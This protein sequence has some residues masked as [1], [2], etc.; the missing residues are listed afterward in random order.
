MHSRSIHFSFRLRH[1]GRM[2]AMSFCNNTYCHLKGCN[3][4]CNFTDLTITEINFMLCRCSFMMRRLHFHSHIFQC[5]NHVTSRIFSKIQR[6][7][8]QV[9]RLLMCHSCRISI[10]I[11]M[12]Q[13]KLTF[14]IN[15]TGI[16]FILCLTCNIFQN[17]SWT[18]LIWRSIRKIQITDHS[19]YFSLLW[20]PWQNRKCIQYWS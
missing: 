6:T 7:D 19:G 15:I 1:K 18:V 16:A 14:R 2:K 3:A 12:K 9:S 5:K 17:I 13:E 10:I 8:I 11:G 20:S 4:I